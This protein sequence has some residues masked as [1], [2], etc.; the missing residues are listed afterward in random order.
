MSHGAGARHR[1]LVHVPC[2]CLSKIDVCPA[3]YH[4]LLSIGRL[5]AGAS[6][7]IVVDLIHEGRSRLADLSLLRFQALLFST[8][9]DLRKLPLNVLFQLFA[10]AFCA[11]KVCL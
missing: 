5:H 7:L 10:A 9:V 8:L 3:N 6:P 11:S 4:W 1:V 2:R